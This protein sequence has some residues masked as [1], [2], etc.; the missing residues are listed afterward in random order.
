MKLNSRA[1]YKLEAVERQC[2]HLLSVII[3]DILKCESDLANAK[4]LN[5]SILEVRCVTR[6]EELKDQRNRLSAL[7][8]YINRNS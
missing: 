2:Q 5:D 8:N 1:D 4:Y 6:L 3:R 7:V